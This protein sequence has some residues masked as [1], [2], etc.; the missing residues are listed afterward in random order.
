MLGVVVMQVFEYELVLLVIMSKVVY[1][2]ILGLDL[3]YG[4]NL[5]N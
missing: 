4:G 5:R 1:F 2:V 3:V